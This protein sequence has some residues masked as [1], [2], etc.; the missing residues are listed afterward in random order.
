M[1]MDLGCVLKTEW[2]GFA[3]RLK[4]YSEEKRNEWKVDC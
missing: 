1:H 4:G 3:Y 2:A